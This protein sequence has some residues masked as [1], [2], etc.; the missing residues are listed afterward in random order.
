MKLGS[1]RDLF[2]HPSEATGARLGLWIAV[3]GLA[4]AFLTQA[5]GVGDWAFLVGMIVLAF[6]TS[7][8]TPPWRRERDHFVGV[9]GAAGAFLV[10]F[11]V[12]GL[13]LTFESSLGFLE[14]SDAPPPS[15]GLMAAWCKALMWSM[16]L[17]LVGYELHRFYSG[18]HHHAA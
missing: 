16:W 11:A 13:I 2:V 15:S 14:P 17:A 7:V 4:T 10:I 1:A 6:A 18:D 12:V 9:A 5:F 3:S 8:V